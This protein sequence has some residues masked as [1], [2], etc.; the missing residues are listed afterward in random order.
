MSVNLEIWNLNRQFEFHLQW[1]RAW[2]YSRT[3]PRFHLWRAWTTEC[4]CM[5]RQRSDTGRWFRRFRLR[6]DISSK[7]SRHGRNRHSSDY[8]PPLRDGMPTSIC[9]SARTWNA[10]HCCAIQWIPERVDPTWASSE[11]D[12]VS[13]ESI[14]SAAMPSISLGVRWPYSVLI[15]HLKRVRGKTELAN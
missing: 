8:P 4:R 3:Q 1:H 5:C 11:L 6:F 13:I 7:G 15:F 2:V 9:S 12:V 14:A 10:Y